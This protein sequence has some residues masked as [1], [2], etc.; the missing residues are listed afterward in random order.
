MFGLE[1]I[2]YKKELTQ[3]FSACFAPVKDELGNVPVIMQT[4]SFVNGAIVAICESYLD[5]HNVKKPSSQAVV[6][7]AVFEE[8]YRRESIK[9][10]TRVD[11]W[12]GLKDQSFVDGYEQAN[13]PSKHNLK[14]T[15]LSVYSQKNI[16]LEHNLML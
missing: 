9:V 15:W 16:D 6:I 2:K 8:I 14:L 4:N 10:Q 13:A 12:R 7:D 3:N 11:E 1:L 5:Q